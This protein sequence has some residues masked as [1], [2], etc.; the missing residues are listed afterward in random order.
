[1]CCQRKG[2]YTAKKN[3]IYILYCLSIF[4]VSSQNVKILKLR[5]ILYIA[6]LCKIFSL[7]SFLLSEFSLKQVNE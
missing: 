6:K 4:V 3:N 5:C 1:M 2:S 7:V